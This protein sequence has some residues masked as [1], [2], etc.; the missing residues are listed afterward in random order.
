M[1]SKVRTKGLHASFEKRGATIQQARRWLFVGRMSLS[2][3]TCPSGDTFV[4]CTGRSWSAKFLTPR[5]FRRLLLLRL[6]E[7]PVKFSLGME[8][9]ESVLPV[10]APDEG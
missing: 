4:A 3:C 7:D 9:A 5:K 2:V 1:P 6:A 8:H 10:Q